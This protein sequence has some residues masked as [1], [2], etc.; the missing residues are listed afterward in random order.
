VALEPIV[1]TNGATFVHSS[2]SYSGKPQRY[3]QVESDFIGHVSELLAKAVD[4]GSLDQRVQPGDRERLIESLRTWGRLD[5]SLS[6]GSNLRSAR[7]RGFDHWPGAGIEGAPTPSSV[8]GL[9]DVLDPIVWKTLDYAMEVESQPT[10]FQLVGGMDM[11]GRA[12]G[13][14]LRDAITL[15]ARVTRIA[16]PGKG[17]VVTFE[18]TRSGAMREAKADWC[19]CT[20][21]LTVLGQIDVQATPEM[22]EAIRGVPYAPHVRIGLE[23]KRRFWEE[24]EAI[25]GGTSWTDQSIRQISY[26]SERMGSAGPAT[27]IGAYQSGTAAYEFAGMTPEARI[28][29]ALSQ[30]EKIHPQYRAE[31][32]NG[33]SVAWHRV[34]WMLGCR[35]EWSKDARDAYY[36]RVC[37]IDGRLVLAGDHCSHLQGWQEGALLSGIDAAKRIHT[38]AVGST[39]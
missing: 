22:L 20:L 34:P 26:P 5:D 35:A 29:A 7:H 3:Q 18:D 15:N 2:R 24:D 28:E 10:M 19:I 39:T 1:T 30:G 16:Q 36:N 33:V 12:F 9:V 23:F 13:E 11:I 32:L 27:L 8:A 25:F 14:H 17:V 21:P 38:R 6:Y 31:Y 37:S 4:A